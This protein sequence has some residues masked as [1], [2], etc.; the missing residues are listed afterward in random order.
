MSFR[1]HLLTCLAWVLLL[2]LQA[3]PNWQSATLTLIDGMTLEGEVD[4]RHWGFHFDDLR[5]RTSAKSDRQR[6]PLNSLMRFEINGR[7]YEVRE[8]TFNASPREPSQLLRQEDR[9]EQQRTAALLVLV[10][11]SVSLYEYADDRGNAHFFL[12]R[13]GEPLRYLDYGRYKLEA[14]NGRTTYNEVNYFR[15]TLIG[16]LSGCERIRQD[17]LQARYRRESLMDVFETYYNC[18]QQRSGYWLERESGIWQF[19]P[20]LGLVKGNPTYGDIEVPVFPFRRLAAWAPGLGAHAKYRFG[21]PH[22][23]VAVRLGVWYHSFAVG[24]TAPDPEEEDPAANANFQYL[25]NERS[26]H[27]QLGPEVILV[28][29]RFPLFLESM[30]EY[31][32]ILDY[33]E[34]RFLTRT[35]NGQTTAD[36][37][38]YDFSNRGAFSLSLGAGIIAGQARL[39][40]RGSATRRKYD[41]YLLNL[42]R[43]SVVGSVDF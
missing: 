18:G 9:A 22:G 8:I 7:R 27:F 42:Y 25:Y 29:S 41:T 32:R 15:S 30:A 4:D 21:G 6:L 28:R 38:S 34:S 14:Y 20:D 36:G 11:G 24:A 13:A 39:S 40:L 33:Q 1:Y 37:V 3:Q 23:S 17:I 26:V 12:R 43:L 5:F 16:Q 31:H 35:V 19:G 2:P 10:E